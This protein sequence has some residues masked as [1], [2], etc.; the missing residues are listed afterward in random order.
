MHS[1][2]KKEYY[3]F[4]NYTINFFVSYSRISPFYAPASDN[5]FGDRRIIGVINKDTTLTQK[6]TSTIDILDSVELTYSTYEH[7]N[8]NGTM[9]VELFDDNNKKLYYEKYDVSKIKDNSYIRLEFDPQHNS[10]G[11]EYTI[12]I[13]FEGLTN[14]EII[15]FWGV[16]DR[17]PNL[18]AT[19]KVKVNDAI[20]VYQYGD[21][22][23]YFYT[24]VFII[25]LLV[26]L[27]IV[28]FKIIAPK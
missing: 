26:E 19:N 7:E 8:K 17:D 10:K 2:E 1:Y 25:I 24:F 16:A 13:N 11:K 3:I 18:Q 5:E 22:K 15:T 12:V 20:R 27:F 14:E 9:V 28:A 21:S 6:F 23:S 4:S